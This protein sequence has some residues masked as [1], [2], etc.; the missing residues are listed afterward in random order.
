LEIP[1]VGYVTCNHFENGGR[2]R[3]AECRRVNHW[4]SQHWRMHRGEE[5][6]S[7]TAEVMM[8]NDKLSIVVENYI[9]VFHFFE[10]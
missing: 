4:S 7:Q 9:F 3:S 8:I 1:I 2:G 6:N 5:A 10:N